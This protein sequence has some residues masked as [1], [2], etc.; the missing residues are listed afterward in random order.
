MTLHHAA[1]ELARPWLQALAVPAQLFGYVLA[2]VAVGVQ[3]VLLTALLM[4]VVLTPVA[5]LGAMVLV[6]TLP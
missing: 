5:V 3:F 4:V 1:H 6:A 2:T